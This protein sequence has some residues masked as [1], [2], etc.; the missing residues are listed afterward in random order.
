MRILHVTSSFKPAWETGGVSRVAYEISRNLAERGHEV[1]VLTT[2]RGRRRVNVQ[3]N[4]P[5]TVDGIRVYY[6]SN[7]SNYLAMK[8]KVTTPYY[9]PFVATREIKHF[10]IIHVHEHRTLLAVI[11]HYYAKKCGI[12]Y[13]SHGHGSVTT[14]FQ[15]LTLKRL[16]DKLWG[17]RML[18]EAT[19]LIALSSV[20]AQ[21]YKSMGV[22]EDKIEIVP[23]GIDLSEFENLPQRG[24]FRERYGLKAE[25]KIVLY[26]GRIHQTKGLDLLAKA[27]AELSKQ[28]DDTKLVIAGPDD[29]YLPALK[30]LIEGLKIEERVLFTGPLYGEEKL[31]AYV[32]ADLF[33]NPHPDEIFG[34]VFLE[35]LACGTPVICSTGCGIADIIDGQAGLA[36]PYDERRLHET[37]QHILGDD[38]MRREFGENGKSLVRER[39]RWEKICEQV[40]NIYEECVTGLEIP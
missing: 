10:D 1:T 4:H 40:E 17:Y 39:F 31:K 8:K 37:L 33:V 15:K 36:V 32:D 7:I 25:Q 13:V 9:L 29:G 16:F 27:F 19:K 3:K 26:L 28:I 5:V 18:K 2:D 35:A 30:R 38:K 20:E 11:V 12:P 21:Q 14:Y 23:N 6:F 22:S 34:I 24:E